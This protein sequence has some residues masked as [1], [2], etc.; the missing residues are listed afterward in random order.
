MEHICRLN[1]I[2]TIPQMIMTLQYQLN[3]LTEA[4]QTLVFSIF[5]LSFVGSDL[6]IIIGF[7]LQ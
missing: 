1:I 7:E 3:T 2:C 5:V 6:V 4:L